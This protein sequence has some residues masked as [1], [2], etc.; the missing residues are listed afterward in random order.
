M[1]VVSGHIVLSPVEVAESF[2]H[3]LIGWQNV[4]TAAGITADTQDP[5]YPA[6]NLAN[7]STFL[8]WHAADTSVQ[9]V[10][11]ATNETDPIDYIGIAKHNLGSAEIPI[12]VEALDDDGV[13]WIEIVEEVM[14]PDDTPA[15]LLFAA[16]SYNDVRLK[17]GS[18]NEPARAA[19]VY[20]GKSLM[21]ERKVYVG[22]TP[23]PM[24]RKSDVSS[25]RSISG[26][27]LGN[28]TLGEWRETSVPFSLFT[29]G[30]Y[31]ANIEPFIEAAK[32]STFFFAWRPNTYPREVGY[33][34]FTDD[35]PIPAATDD[36]NLIAFNFN[37]AGV[38]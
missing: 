9:Y 21:M 28:I 5:S 24:G 4:V 13:T 19:V 14:L 29:P 1:I 7:P 37:L 33:C 10:R 12:S 3:P 20:V 6:T 23:I 38:A 26:N 2:D 36:G 30:W 11:F 8:E 16:K 32:D 27:F 25:Q 18:G 35:G 31:R 34:W 17:L 22:H 15:M